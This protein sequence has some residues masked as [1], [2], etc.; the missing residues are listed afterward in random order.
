MNDCKSGSQVCSREKG[1]KV[2]FFIAKLNSPVN[3]TV[4]AF[5]REKSDGPIYLYARVSYVYTFMRNYV[6]AEFSKRATVIVS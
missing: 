5:R 4:L 6:Y 2:P 1:I 3:R